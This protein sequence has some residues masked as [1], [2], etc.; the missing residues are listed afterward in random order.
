VTIGVH[1]PRA[2]VFLGRAIAQG[3]TKYRELSPVLLRSEEVLLAAD[4]E[5]WGPRVKQL[6]ESKSFTRNWER[7][8]SG[9]RDW[10][11]DQY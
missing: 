1:I 6:R 5:K 8:A 2:A 10:I 4:P 7:E 9:M 3:G 11:L